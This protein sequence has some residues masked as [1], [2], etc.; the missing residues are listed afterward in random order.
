[1]EA[2]NGRGIGAASGSRKLRRFPTIV[3]RASVP[4]RLAI[5]GPGWSSRGS[6]EC[7]GRLL[8]ACRSGG[9][10]TETPPVPDLPGRPGTRNAQHHSGSKRTVPAPV[11][12]LV[13]IHAQQLLPGQQP[14][15][16]GGG[17]SC[18]RFPQ[19]ARWSRKSQQRKRRPPEQH[20]WQRQQQ[21]Q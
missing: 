14:T 2:A 5:P 20:R 12:I 18:G 15:G 8:S 3:R 6:S 9:R 17:G 21:Q 16:G 1:M 4:W 11:G 7:G 10:S 19:L 13:V